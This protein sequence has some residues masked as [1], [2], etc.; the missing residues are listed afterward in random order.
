MNFRAKIQILPN[1][2]LLDP[3]GKAV[4]LGLSN[5]GIKSIQDVRVGKF[6]T[7][8]IEAENEEEAHN[9]AKEACEKLL[10]NRIMEQFEFVVEKI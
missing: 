7:L 4:L 2:E 9:A 8:D 10:H 5:L 6:I 3:Q 1:K